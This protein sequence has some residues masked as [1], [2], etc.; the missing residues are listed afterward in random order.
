MYKLISFL[1]LFSL[2]AICCGRIIELDIQTES[3]DFFDIS[4]DY[5]NSVEDFD[6][7][8]SSCSIDPAD[9]ALLGN[10]VGLW[11]PCKEDRQIIYYGGMLPSP[12]SVRITGFWTNPL[13]STSLRLIGMKSLLTPQEDMFTIEEFSL[14]GAEPGWFNFAVDLSVYTSEYYVYA[15]N[16]SRRELSDTILID[17]VQLDL[18]ND[19]PDPSTDPPTSTSSPIEDGKITLDTDEDLVAEW[20]ADVVECVYSQDYM[21]FHYGWGCP[22]NIA[23][24]GVDPSALSGLWSPCSQ[25]NCSLVFDGTNLPQTQFIALQAYI[26]GVGTKL[27]VEGKSSSAGSYESLLNVDGE[28][29]LI[30]LPLGIDLAAIFPDAKIFK[31]TLTPGEDGYV[32]IDK[33]IL[34]EGE[35]N[36]TEAPTLF[37]DTTIAPTTEPAKDASSLKQSCLSLF[38]AAA[39]VKYLF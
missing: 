19:V 4:C 29:G 37:P 32:L 38:L 2:T 6:P 3:E 22:A 30:S 12:K 17:S 23:Q 21:D 13:E 8:G 33:I 9:L 35:I 20:S 15:I 1:T 36:L 11:S 25:P 18:G 28:N 39:F 34:A 31:F 16:I 5:V 7:F 10:P 27:V 14:S 24:H 26:K